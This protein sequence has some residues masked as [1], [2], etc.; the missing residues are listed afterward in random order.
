MSNKFTHE[1]A[2]ARPEQ[3]KLLIVL[4]DGMPS[5][6]TPG[7][8]KGA[9]EEARRQGIHVTGIYFEEGSCGRDS[10][11][12]KQMY[13]GKGAGINDAICCELSELDKN[14]EAVIDYPQVA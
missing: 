2:L 3:K 6:A 11:Q 9:I 10:D 12:F 5:E 13:G 7:F 14:L 8:T 1:D 4:S